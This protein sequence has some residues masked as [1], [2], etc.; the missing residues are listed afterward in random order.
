MLWD[1]FVLFFISSR[2]QVPWVLVER[3][4]SSSDHAFVDNGN[5]NLNLSATNLIAMGVFLVYHKKGKD[6]SLF[7]TLSLTPANEYLHYYK[8]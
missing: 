1:S 8:L 6:A 7:L 5:K 4:T 3:P 2:S